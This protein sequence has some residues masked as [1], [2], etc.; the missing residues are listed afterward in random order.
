MPHFAEGS[1]LG[2]LFSGTLAGPSAS[3]S[4]IGTTTLSTT[5]DAAKMAGPDAAFVASTTT[6]QS[7]VAQFASAVT[8]AVGGGVGTGTGVGGTGT[9]VFSNIPTDWGSSS[10]G[11]TA[12]NDISALDAVSQGGYAVPSG[13]ISSVSKASSGSGFSGIAS[14]LAHTGDLKAVFTGQTYSG[15]DLTGAQQAGAAIGTAGVV[16]GGA[17]A[18][19]SGFKKGGVRGDLQGSAAILGTAAA[20]DPE[21]VSKM[22]L[23]GVAMVTGL[24]TQMLGDPKQLRAEAIDKTLGNAKYE[25]PEAKNVSM[26]VNGGYSDTS[27]FG[28]VRSSDLSPYPTGQTDPT[29]WYRNGTYNPIAGSSGTPYGAAM[30]PQTVVHVAGDVIDPQEF[31]NRNGVAL[32]N[33]MS[34]QFG[35][36]TELAMA[37]TKATV[38]G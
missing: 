3:K 21:P 26:G 4:R 5:S 29:Q 19:Y 15:T 11:P 2:N 30:Q 1:T 33:T 25:A 36:H 13:S 22:V 28:D 17:E 14:G 35:T 12:L 27:A 34:S 9:G 38:G 6:F 32:G 7:S 24:V 8:A 23:S 10:G 20:L 37:A 31:F 18:A 16:I